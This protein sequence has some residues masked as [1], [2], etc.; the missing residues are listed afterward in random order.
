MREDLEPQ[1][2]DKYSM[3]CDELLTWKTTAYNKCKEEKGSDQDCG[4]DFYLAS[5]YKPLT[6]EEQ[7]RRG[8][9]SRSGQQRK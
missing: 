6:I 2:R 3:S 4:N 8:M 9:L 5:K 7:R 1:C